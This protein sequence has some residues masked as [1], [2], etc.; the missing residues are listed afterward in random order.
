VKVVSS[1]LSFGL[2]VNVFVLKKI[3]QKGEEKVLSNNLLI[4]A[5]YCSL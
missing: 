4:I 3:K 1:V 5:G 2:F